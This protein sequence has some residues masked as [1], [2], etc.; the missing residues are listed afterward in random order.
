MVRAS[1]RERR[2]ALNATDG[3]RREMAVRK[4]ALVEGGNLMAAFSDCVRA[5]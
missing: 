2:D 5:S 3:E 1:E 4:A